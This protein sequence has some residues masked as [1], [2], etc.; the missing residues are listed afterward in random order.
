MEPERS[1]QDEPLL[2]G[3][4]VVERALHAIGGAV[5]EVDGRPK[6]VLEVGL[7]T[8]VSKGGD[9]G[10]EDVRDGAAD[11]LGFGRRSRVG[12][13][14]G[15]MIAVKL[16]LGA[17]VI[18]GR[19]PVHGLEIGVVAIGLHG[20]ALVGY[21][22]ACLGLPAIT[23]GGRTGPAP[24]SRPKRSEGRQAADILLRDAKASELAGGK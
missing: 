24:L 5:E 3:L 8:R 14:R 18:S 7:E 9:Q 19:C 1:R 15:W 12:L 6:Q 20:D 13:V 16:K 22:H 23:D 21:G 2:G 10:V 4:V 11:N 17:D